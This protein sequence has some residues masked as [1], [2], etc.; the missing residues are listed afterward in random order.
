M[1]ALYPSRESDSISQ[2]TTRRDTQSLIAFLQ[3]QTEES[4]TEKQKE[5]VL[6]NIPATLNYKRIDKVN[7]PVAK[8]IMARDHKGFGTGFNTM[9]GV[10]KWKRNG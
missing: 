1:M 5:P 8:T 4:V 7:T 9:N 3:E 6:S 2:L 10:I